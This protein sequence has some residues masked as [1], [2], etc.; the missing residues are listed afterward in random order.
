MFWSIN[1]IK[2]ST[3]LIF[4]ELK[5]NIGEKFKIAAYVILQIS[6]SL[7]ETYFSH[8][9]SNLE[10]SLSKN[11]DKENSNLLS[12]IGPFLMPYFFQ[13]IGKTISAI[14]TSH[15]YKNTYKKVS[16][17]V[18]E[19]TMKPKNLLEADRSL[20]AG[21][22]SEQLIAKYSR[23]FGSFY[24]DAVSAAISTTIKFAGGVIVLLQFSY[25]LAATVCCLS[26]S[27]GYCVSYICKKYSQNAD[28]Q[29]IE[30][31]HLFKITQ[32]IE[33]GAEALA[34]ING[35]KSAVNVFE[36]KREE[37]IALVKKGGQINSLMQGVKVL[38][39][40]ISTVPIIVLAYGAISPEYIRQAAAITACAV[41]EIELRAVIVYLSI[42][43]DRLKEYVQHRKENSH[44]VSFNINF[45]NSKNINIK[46]I[47]LNSPTGG[48]KVFDKLSIDFSHGKSKDRGLIYRLIGS[49]G[50][51]KSCL[52]RIISRSLSANSGN[53][54][55]PY[56][57]SDEKNNSIRRIDAG[58]I[59]KLSDSH[60]VKDIALYPKSIENINLEIK[61]LLKDNENISRDNS[62]K[63]ISK[64]LSK[65]GH[66][67]SGNEKNVLL[68]K[69][70]TEFPNQARIID[71]VS[72]CIQQARIKKIE[73]LFKHLDQSKLF[74]ETIK[75]KSDGQIQIIK[76]VQLL[77]SC[78]APDWIIL[79]EAFSNLTPN[80][81]TKIQKLLRET[82]PKANI[83]FI[84]HYLGNDDPEWPIHQVF[85]IQNSKA[86]RVMEDEKSGKNSTASKNK[87]ALLNKIDLQASSCKNNKD[88]NVLDKISISTQTEEHLPISRESR[89]GLQTPVMQNGGKPSP[90]LRGNRN[91][92]EIPPLSGS[93]NSARSSRG[94]S[95]SRQSISENLASPAPQLSGR[96]GISFAARVSSGR[97]EDKRTVSIS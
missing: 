20:K 61:S 76:I 8:T 1:V 22:G 62:V 94:S 67:L 87:L 42:Y 93:A 97:E 5:I 37:I 6:L 95:P 12:I 9:I 32:Q 43:T 66:I 83:I 7:L 75:G 31:N 21:I 51:G 55:L 16:S 92:E 17:E 84:D 19:D 49:N 72:E 71:L 64:Y 29:D 81:I 38:S 78:P 45:N 24:S 74:T 65:I 25:L 60:S 57:A 48:D 73:E 47:N 46:N 88:P 50:A 2:D 26:I 44:N 54:S 90:D 69:V 39:M 27:L 30:S 36:K 14:S 91:Y 59:F 13:A 68:K 3:I 41:S 23:Y 85:A 34:N 58:K 28:A 96:R 18:L 15:L 89:S 70:G 82:F 33:N 4:K 53:V 79:D 52:S 80:N 63:S 86:S 35:K 77:V 40:V 10:R 56:L 11:N